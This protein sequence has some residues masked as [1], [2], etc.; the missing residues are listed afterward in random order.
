MLG[1]V[2][3][4]VIKNPTAPEKT[5]RGDNLWSL[6]FPSQMSDILDLLLSSGMMLAKLTDIFGM[7]GS[8]MNYIHV[9]MSELSVVCLGFIVLNHIEPHCSTCVRLFFGPL[10]HSLI[11][12]GSV[13][14]AS[15]TLSLHC[16]VLRIDTLWDLFKLCKPPGYPWQSYS[17]ETRP[18]QVLPTSELE[19]LWA[20][21]CIYAS[22]FG[23]IACIKRHI[24][25]TYSAMFIVQVLTSTDNPNY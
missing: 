13:P 2:S 14:T 19:H 20:Q 1:L 4:F 3:I 15:T 11:H 12:V 22:E 18:S 7:N 6:Q 8:N 21:P 9:F 17:T 23:N 5:P 10:S 24:I 25:Y 16:L